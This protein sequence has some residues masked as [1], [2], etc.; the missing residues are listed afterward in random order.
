MPLDG[1]SGSARTRTGTL[2]VLRRPLYSQ[3]L[4]ANF[5]T[6]M[7][8]WLYIAAAAWVMLE[9]TGSPLMVGLVSGGTFVPRL[10]FAVPAGAL[11]DVFDRRL[12]IL[13]GNL[14]QAAVALTAG[15][16]QATGT[17]GP[18]ALMLLTLGIG[19][20]QALSMP[21]YHSAINDVV[22]RDEVAA[23]VTL[24]SG[25]VNVARAIGP[26]VGGGF[27]AAGHTALAFTFTGVS[28][29]A[30]CL[31]ALRI[32]KHERSA[33][34]PEPMVSAMRTGIRFVRHSPLLLRLFALSALFVLASANI[35]ALLAPAAAGR[36]LGAQGY[37]FLFS[38]FG[39]GALGGALVTRRLSHTL[40]RLLKP[41]SIS[42]FGLGGIAFAY[43]P[44]NT[45]AAGA[46]ALTGAAWVVTF[47]TLNSMVQLTAPPWVR[48][49]VLSLYMMAFT[50][51]WPVGTSFA[52]ALA[53]TVG[54]APA[55]ALTSAGVVGVAA[56]AWRLR[57]P[58]LR[59]IDRP[60]PAD[61]WPAVSH[62]PNVQ[63]SPVAVLVTW[64]V[65]AENVPAF[66]RAMQEVRRCRLRS[67]ASRWRLCHDPDQ[68][69]RLTELFEVPDWD[70]HLRQH[71]R[72]DAAAITALRRA[73]ALSGVQEPEVRH[74]V[75]LPADVDSAATLWKPILDRRSIQ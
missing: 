33:A 40:G 75:G 16:M 48:G 21:A 14:F 55:I 15:I 71:G 43:V 35:Q 23:A 46:I 63:G 7:G 49:R 36:G 13:V 59:E 50:G 27:I 56:I 74:L 37:G 11:I 5:I 62:V 41:V 24:H 17:L 60:A 66:V 29:L 20:G 18:W 53:D 67:G 69:E 61:Q 39:V 3:L 44:W 6:A 12:M 9:L 32:P 8:V 57:L 70:E 64:T 72:L 4:G 34:K 52:G 28:Y 10:I 51:A 31:A 25:S 45:A 73:K 38:C 19:T 26:A 2:Q 65:P 54:T 1:A 58:A 68:P 22:P 30:L 47:A 42:A